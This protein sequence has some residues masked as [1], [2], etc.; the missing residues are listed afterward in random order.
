MVRH[1]AAST[2][3]RSTSCDVGGHRAAATA[4]ALDRADD[5]TTMMRSDD[6]LGDASQAWS[7]TYTRNLTL[8]CVTCLLVTFAYLRQRNSSL[9]G[10]LA[11]ERFWVNCIFSRT[12]ET[13]RQAT[14]N[15]RRAFSKVASFAHGLSHIRGIHELTRLTATEENLQISA[16][17]GTRYP[18]LAAPAHRQ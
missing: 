12:S 13:W 3:R 14:H 11:E 4:G 17:K 8:T 18:L 10:R 7:S 16:A 5:S 15:E 6:I 1:H 2:I 9:E